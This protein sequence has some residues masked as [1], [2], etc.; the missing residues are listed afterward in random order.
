[1]GFLSDTW[2]W[3]DKT[4][5]KIESVFDDVGTFFGEGLVG[6]KPGA[7]TR[8]PGNA[9]WQSR[10]AAELNPDLKQNPAAGSFL[11][12]YS[13]ALRHSGAN[14]AASAALE[15][16]ARSGFARRL[17]EIAPQTF[18]RYQSLINA[19]KSARDKIDTTAP[20]AAW[21]EG[22]LNGGGGQGLANIGQLGQGDDNS[23]QSEQG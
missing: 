19:L 7:P 23:N 12:A 16:R 2:H 11:P 10:L 6:K 15:K 9:P 4:G 14:P 13:S 21:L 1:M 17:T 22:F 20:E 3:L 5:D 8:G 18:G